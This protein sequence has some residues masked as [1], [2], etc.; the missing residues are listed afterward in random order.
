MTLV[1]EEVYIVV[2]DFGALSDIVIYDSIEDTF[3][4]LK[5]LDP[6]DCSDTKVFHG[7]LAKAD[8][9]PDD[10]MKRSCFIMAIKPGTGIE[11][12]ALS[13]VLMESDCDDDPRILA[14][15]IEE[16]VENPNVLIYNLNIDDVYV[17][18]GYRVQLGICINDDSIDEENI[19]MCKKV[20]EKAE[21]LSSNIAK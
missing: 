8:A 21:E 14:S 13:G 20:A 1:N 4:Y 2:E 7:I 15:E 9:I 17:L 12:V 6:E 18:Y 10:L 5:M 11:G 3:E 16:L 19:E